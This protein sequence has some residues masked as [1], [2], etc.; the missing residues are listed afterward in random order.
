MFFRSKAYL[1]FLWNSTN[2]HGVHSPFVFNLITKCFY[3]RKPKNEY[4]ILKNFR[5]TVFSN[6]KNFIAIAENADLHGVSLI[7]NA[8]G[9]AGAN[10]EISSKH[11]KLLFRLCDYFKPTHILEV[12]SKYG[13][14]T[15]ALALGN[16]KATIT[17][18]ENCKN[19]SDFLK[20]Q[21]QD[22][23]IKNVRLCKSSFA[24]YINNHFIINTS[25]LKPVYYQLIFFSLQK[26]SNLTY[27]D[28]LLATSTN[29]S[30]WIFD[31]IHKTPETEAA[32]KNIK[33]NPKVTVTIDTYYWGLVFF[34]REQEKEHF[35]IRL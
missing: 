5:T 18:F 20:E 7:P 33:S 12:E 34:R 16:P 29:E 15:A 14:A 26:E 27:F 28:S 10:A 1:K 31:A 35:V 32:W 3:D 23:N 13:L 25:H 9:K 19:Q 11:C 8:A 6:K 17:A 30:V 4:A 21:F 24:E 2:E 22:L